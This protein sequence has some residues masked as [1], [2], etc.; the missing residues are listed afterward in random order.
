MAELAV[1]AVRYD[2][3]LCPPRSAQAIIFSC[4]RGWL[5]VLI[6]FMVMPKGPEDHGRLMRNGYDHFGVAQTPIQILK[7]DFPIRIVNDGDPV[8]FDDGGVQDFGKALI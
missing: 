3:A 7:P 4:N 1:L 6:A 2:S 8:R 5:R